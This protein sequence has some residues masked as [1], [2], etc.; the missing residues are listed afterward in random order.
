MPVLIEELYTA[1]ECKTIREFY[2]KDESL[3]GALREAIGSKIILEKDKILTSKPL[4]VICLVC[5]TSKFASSEDECHRVAVT[6][7]Q[8]IDRPKD[9][10]P[11]ITEDRD[12][13]FANKT[14]IAL[15]FCAKA[16][17]R[18]WKRHG[19]PAPS[20]YRKASKLVFNKHGQQDIA[21]HHEQWEGFIGELFV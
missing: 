20:Y 5:L 8:Y 12:L 14:L 21:A 15:S 2:Q 10:L 19:A 16:L 4:D 18:R 3:R 17:E 7:Y 1:K 9:I 11:Y 13:T 6:I